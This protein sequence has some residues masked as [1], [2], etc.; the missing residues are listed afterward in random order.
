M[1]TP[2]FCGFPW[3]LPR[4]GRSAGPSAR[5]ASQVPV[6]R[7]R[8]IGRGDPLSVQ[9]DHG[10]PTR[11]KV[12]SWGDLWFFRH[13]REWQGV[14]GIYSRSTGSSSLFRP[15]DNLETEKRNPYFPVYIAPGRSPEFP[16]EPNLHGADRL[17]PRSD[18]RNDPG[19]CNTG[20]RPGTYQCH[21]AIVATSGGAAT[22]DAGSNRATGNTQSMRCTDRWPSRGEGHKTGQGESDPSRFPPCSYRRD[23]ELT[24]RAVECSKQQAHSEDVKKCRGVSFQLADSPRKLGKLEA[25]PTFSP[26]AGQ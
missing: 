13:F 24:R 9:F 5:N 11:K 4:A 18:G 25:Y 20:G 14:L 19:S 22:S 26:C 3:A 10:Q 21:S 17:R 8:E 23:G 1:R 6:G 16:E 15:F 2:V 7:G 12:R